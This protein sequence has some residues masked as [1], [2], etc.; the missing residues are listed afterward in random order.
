[1]VADYSFIEKLFEFLQINIKT[2]LN[3]F[4]HGTSVGR[5]KRDKIFGLKLS[6]QVRSLALTYGY[7]KSDMDNKS[8]PFW[9][10]YTRSAQIIH[11]NK[12]VARS[13]LYAL[14]KQLT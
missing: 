11:R 8:N 5:W 9:P 14:K 10:Y 2:D 1:M 12:K 3:D 13:F 4:L 6:E 7:Q